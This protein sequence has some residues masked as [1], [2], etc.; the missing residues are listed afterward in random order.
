MIGDMFGKYNECNRNISYCDCPDICSVE[1][2]KS[3]ECLYKR[4]VGY[5]NKT[6]KSE[7][8]KIIDKCGIVNNHQR[9]ISGSFPYK[10]KACGNKITGKYTNDKW[11]E[12]QHFLAVHRAQHNYTKSDQS[13]DY[14]Y[15]Q[16]GLPVS[17]SDT[18]DIE[19]IGTLLSS[20]TIS[21]VS[22]CCPSMVVIFSTIVRL[23]TSRFSV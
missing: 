5:C 18:T 9:R 20:S 17:A 19:S 8:F 22:F 2:A 6:S 14:R 4:K 3:T 1:F 21:I 13:A 12:F 15:I 23:F 11:N 16:T 10:E 7:I